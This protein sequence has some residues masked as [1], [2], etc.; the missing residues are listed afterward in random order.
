MSYLKKRS[1]QPTWTQ[2]KDVLFYFTKGHAAAFTIGLNLLYDMSKGV[3]GR[4]SRALEESEFVEK[5]LVQGGADVNLLHRCFPLK[6]MDDEEY[7]TILDTLVT[8][9]NADMGED[10]VDLQVSKAIL[11]L[12]KAG[13]MAPNGKFS[14]PA[15]VRYYYGQVFPKAISLPILPTESLDDLIVKATHVVSE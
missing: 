13:L 7:Q 12:R 14:S 1:L 5:C 10:L 9:Y 4:S 6:E 15:A 2:F 3:G 8:A 11:E